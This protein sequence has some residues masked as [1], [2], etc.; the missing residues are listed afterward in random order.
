MKKGKAS[1]IAIAVIAGAI[2]FGIASLSDEVLLENPTGASE[3][4][5]KETLQT[6]VQPEIISSKEQPITPQKESI[7]PQEESEPTDTESETSEESD[8]NVIEVKI[9]DGV[10]STDR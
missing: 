8:G 1:G 2:V 5:P 9:S 7:N 6:E 10:G 3:N 4:T